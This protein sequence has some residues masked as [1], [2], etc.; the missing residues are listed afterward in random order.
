MFEPGFT[1]AFGW[2]VVNLIPYS[3]DV[4]IRN[5]KRK[6]AYYLELGWFYHT[7]AE[8]CTHPTVSEVKLIRAMSF[9]GGRCQLQSLGIV[10][11]NI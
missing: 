4:G 2:L 9:M 10:Q 7:W 5:D 6:M 11:P 3:N 8:N 1:T